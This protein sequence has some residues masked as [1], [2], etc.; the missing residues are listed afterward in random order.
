M[1]QSEVE[2]KSPIFFTKLWVV[3]GPFFSEPKNVS[4]MQGILVVFWTSLKAVSKH[5]GLCLILTSSKK[6][7]VVFTTFCVMF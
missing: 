6:K 3:F 4:S 7:V 5:F 1:E 2:Q